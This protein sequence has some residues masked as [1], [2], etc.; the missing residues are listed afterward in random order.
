M[1][2]PNIRDSKYYGG[3]YSE[4]K[5]IFKDVP[6]AIFGRQ[7]IPP[8][9]PVVLP[10]MTDAE[11]LDLYRRMCVF[12]YPSIE[13]RHVHY[14]PIEAMIVGTPVLYRSGGMLDHLAGQRLPACCD[15]KEEIRERALRLLSG[16]IR[17]EVA[18]RESQEKIIEKFSTDLV[19]TEWAEVLE[20]C[21][22][23]LDVIRST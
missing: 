15:S 8:G 1:L 7:N 18:I 9:D 11:L 16:D 12:A 6:H 19:R 4:L 20:Q 3:I 23:R 2:C 5:A 22:S 13:P 10:Y 17:L 21:C 14:S